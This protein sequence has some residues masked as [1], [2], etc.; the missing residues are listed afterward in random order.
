MFFQLNFVLGILSE[1]LA[2]TVITHVGEGVVVAR[3][4]RGRSLAVVNKCHFT[5]VLPL[6]QQ[7]NLLVF[8]AAAVAHTNLTITLTDKVHVL[9]GAIVVLNNDFFF[10][11]IQTC[12]ELADQ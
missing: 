7:S 8:V 12:S 9:V 1:Q 2:E 11:N 5:E 4:H 10:R 6:H 3:N